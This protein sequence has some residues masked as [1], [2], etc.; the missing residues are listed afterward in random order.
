MD[1]IIGKTENIEYNIYYDNP[2]HIPGHI[3]LKHI[4]P[5]YED[6]PVEYVGYRLEDDDIYDEHN[7]RRI[8]IPL[9]RYETQ[10]QFKVL[11]IVFTCD[12][13]KKIELLKN[14]FNS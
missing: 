10:L 3:V 6:I 14:K 12:D 2:G 9:Y 8:R 11:W 7:S 13:Y 4:Y 5:V 1:L